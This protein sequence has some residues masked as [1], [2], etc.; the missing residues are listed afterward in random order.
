MKRYR[1]NYGNGQICYAGSLEACKR[2]ITEM[3]LYQA[4]AFIE[5]QD[6]ET[7]DWF[8]YRERR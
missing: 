7:G 1:V 8:R 6:W 2:H 3:D 5:W 4:Y